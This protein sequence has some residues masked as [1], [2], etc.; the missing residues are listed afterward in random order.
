MAR[1]LLIVLAIMDLDLALRADSP[2]PFMDENTSN[3]KKDLRRCEKS[4]YMCMMIMKKVILEAFK[5]SIYEKITIDKEFL[6]DIKKTFVKN[7]NVEI[8]TL[9]TKV[10]SGSTS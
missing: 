1:E 3:G 6:T 5:G 7:E 8:V 10:I 2:P 4:N 9:L